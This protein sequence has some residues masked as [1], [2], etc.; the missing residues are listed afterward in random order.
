MEILRKKGLFEFLVIVLSFLIVISGCS[1]GGELKKNPATEGTIKIGVVLP[2]TGEVATYG[3]S[4]K[5]G[6]ELAV[7]RINES[8]GVLGKKIDLIIEDDKNDLKETANKVMKLIEEDNV[9]AIIGSVTS[10]CTLADM[11][12]ANSKNVPMVTPAST[13]PKVTKIGPYCFRVCFVDDFQGR[14]MAKF[15][16]EDLNTK[17]AAL[18]FNSEDEYS[19]GLAK[20]FEKSFKDMGGEIVAAETYKNADSDF[21]AQLSKIKELEPEVIF[22][23]GYY[24]KLALIA[25]Q[26]RALGIDATFLGGD[27][28][29][30]REL[31]KQ[32]GE[33]VNGSY[34]SSH[35][36]KDDPA[37]EVQ[38]FVNEYKE[39]Y[40]EEARP[41]S[42]LGYDAL[43]F[44][45]DGIKNAGKEDPKAIRDAL[46]SIKNFSGATGNFSINE[47]RNP[48]KSAVVFKIENGKQV[49][50]KRVEPGE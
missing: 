6:I 20:Y 25:K 2:L 34:Y 14:V 26:A 32:A 43:Y 1:T 46:G 33:A 41:I 30:S 37:P 16:R 5:K 50:V 39:K 8:G 48:I 36:S 3:Q 4:A 21:N 7:E 17:R 12:V 38:E 44:L 31:V 40:G 13:N 22:L 49:F 47:N 24:Q 15:A 27:G 29:A 19:K 9:V 28:W 11:P 35:F 10:K 45:A 18:I 42:A 23:P